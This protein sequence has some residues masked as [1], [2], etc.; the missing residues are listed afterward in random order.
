MEYFP[1]YAAQYPCSPPPSRRLLSTAIANF[2][3]PSRRLLSA[4]DCSPL[5]IALRCRLLSAVA[6]S[7]LSLALLHHLVVCSLPPS[8]R[9]LSAAI[10]SLALRRH[11]VA[12]ILPP[13]RRLLSSSSTCLI[14]AALSSLA[15]LQISAIDSSGARLLKTL[16]RTLSWPLGVSVQSTS[17]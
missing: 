5:S 14:F 4:V 12:C 10:S 3:P 9:L 1:R 11:L 8:G 7:P 6:C 17:N 2:S 15:L 16:T 13:S